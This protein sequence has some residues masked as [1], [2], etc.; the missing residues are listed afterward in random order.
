MDNWWLAT[1]S[2]VVAGVISSLIVMLI[3]SFLSPRVERQGG[4]V[5][6]ETDIQVIETRI[7]RVSPNSESSE[8]ERIWFAFVTAIV[9]L[10][11]FY[12]LLKVIAGIVLGAAFATLLILILCIVRSQKLR[13]WL[14]QSWTVLTYGV[15]TF[16]VVSYAWWLVFFYAHDG[17]SALQISESIYADGEGSSFLSSLV[18]S[19]FDAIGEAENLQFA[20]GILAAVMLS[21]ALL[22]MT[23]I[24][25]YRWV[26]FLSI[27]YST[28]QRFVKIRAKAAAHF[29][30]LKWQ[31]IWVALLIAAM[32][33]LLSPPV[34]SALFN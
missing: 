9:A 11:A 10:I 26:A 24:L 15:I 12:W 19:F 2:A 18:S 25:A 6:I 4:S 29:L 5:H 16:A 20:V 31:E 8:N 32:V 21:A 33:V 13:L 28:P 14:T 27:A 17:V 7:E 30:R 34:F 22:S 3:Q 23:L 1:A